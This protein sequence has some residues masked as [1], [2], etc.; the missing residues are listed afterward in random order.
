MGQSD[1]KNSKVIGVD[2]GGRETEVFRETL[3]SI[4]PYKPLREF[5]P[6]KKGLTQRI[7]DQI[8]CRASSGPCA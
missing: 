3:S 1:R 5:L 6:P 4:Q 2:E 7:R 8:V